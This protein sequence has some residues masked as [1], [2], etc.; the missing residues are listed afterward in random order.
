MS[1]ILFRA[2][3]I[4]NDDGDH[5]LWNS[6]VLKGL[7]EAK[8]ISLSM[9]INDFIMSSNDVRVE[10]DHD[11]GSISDEFRTVANRPCKN[12]VL[13]YRSIYR[14]QITEQIEIEEGGKK[15]LVERVLSQGSK[16]LMQ[17]FSAKIAGPSVMLMC[18]VFYLGIIVR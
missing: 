9:P 5:I 10:S 8:K 6:V 17:P 18:L 11:F 15:I 16:R 2:P 3:E 13:H 12:L 1:L 4:L 14:F 7:P